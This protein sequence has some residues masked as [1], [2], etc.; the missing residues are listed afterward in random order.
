MGCNLLSSCFWNT[1]K[2]TR[3]FSLSLSR[4]HTHV[5]ADTKPR[6]ICLSVGCDSG[7]TRLQIHGGTPLHTF[8]C[9]F[10]PTVICNDE[11]LMPFTAVMLLLCYIY[12]HYNTLLIPLVKKNKQKKQQL[13]NTF[14]YYRSL[15]WYVNNQHNE[16]FFEMMICTPPPHTHTHTLNAC[17]C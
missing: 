14:T 13:T 12:F 11:Q 2:H 8:N 3:A 1:G 6:A 7:L 17:T 16:A 4:T 15:G 9:L 10:A 5:S